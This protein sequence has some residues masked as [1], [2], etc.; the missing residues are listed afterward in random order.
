MAANVVVFLLAMAVFGGVQIS[1]SSRN[2]ERLLDEAMLARARDMARGPRPGIPPGQR[3]GQGEGQSNPEGR[4]LDG[5]PP[6][7]PGGGEAQGAG[8]NP[9]GQGR[10]PPA[11]P[12]RFHPSVTRR[13]GFV[14]A[15]GR[16]LPVSESRPIWSPALLEISKAGK[17]AFGYENA[18]NMR[19]RVAS[20][21]IPAPNGKFDVVQVAEDASAIDLARRSQLLSLAMV[22]PFALLAALVAAWVLARFVIEPVATI[23]KWAVKLAREPDSD[24]R[25]PPQS[26]AEIDSLAASVNSMADGMQSANEHIRESLERQRQFTSDAAHELR[27]PL[28]SL[29]LAAENGLHDD[30]TQDEMRRSLEVVQ[31]SASSLGG[32]LEMLLSLS[33]L[34]SSKSL[35]QLG[36]VD[37]EAAAASAIE[38]AGLKDDS[39]VTLDLHS[40]AVW[41]NAGA[42]QQILVNLLTNAAAHTGADGEIRIEFSGGKL[43]VADNGSGIASE[44][45]PK[46]FDRFY[47]VDE[48]RN[49]AHGGYGLGLAIVKSLIEAQGGS[50]LVESQVGV[51]TKFF[52]QFSERVENS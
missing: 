16:V 25:I 19:V 9:P 38:A 34:D 23:S 30:A 35:L 4:P 46:I 26:T 28:T 40:A 29:K 11:F 12:D 33:R 7:A 37:L 18:F 13:P 14:M 44:H 41:A 15:D 8:Q 43:V 2:A 47:R 48:A 52:V 3:P 10:P 42:V 1:M 6:G 31:R 49:R 51:G 27:T 39:R 50:V 24:D 45:L 22:L 17:V 5:L 36:E 20:M 21:P 32:L